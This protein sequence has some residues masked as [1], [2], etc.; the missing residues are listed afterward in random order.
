LSLV[1][2]K[3]RKSKWYRHDGVNWLPDNSLQADTLVDLKTQNNALSIYLVQDDESDLE[4]LIA[5]LA[6]T[7]DNLANFDYA[8]FDEAILREANLKIRSQPGG[9]PDQIVNAIQHRDLIELTTDGVLLLARAIRDGRRERK[10][11]AEVSALIT[12]SIKDGH[13]AL[14]T[15]K[16]ELRKRFTPS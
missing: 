15:L 13:F 7:G 11:D 10:M 3:I 5:A 16:P 14:E 1:L 2:R 9:T 12:K 4:R 6:A 8:L